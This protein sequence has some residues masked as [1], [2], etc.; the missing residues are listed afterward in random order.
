[1]RIFILL[2]L[3]M[4]LVS[5]C[6]SHRP[7]PTIIQ[8]AI[9]HPARSDADRELDDGRKPAEVIAFFKIEPSMKVIDIFGGGGYYTELISYIVGETGSV[10]L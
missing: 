6:T 5:G 4:T 8:D 3:S 2:T 10:T 7:D 9:E 1:M